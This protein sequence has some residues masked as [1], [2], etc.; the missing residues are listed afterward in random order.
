M[1]AMLILIAGLP[2]TGKTTI[3]RAFANLTGATHLNSDTIRRGLGLMGHYSPED[4]DKVYH[5]LLLRAREAL[6]RQEIVVVDSTFYKEMIRE[7]FC[8]LAAEC[9]VPLYWVEVQASEQILRQRLSQ[10][11]PDSEADFQVYQTIRDQSEP[12]PKDRLI[13]QSETETPETAAIKI[14]KHLKL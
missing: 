4:K 10:P 14:Q 9:G 2:G 7:P 11:R 3:A 5:N 6:L 1:N 12:L 8:V 13:I